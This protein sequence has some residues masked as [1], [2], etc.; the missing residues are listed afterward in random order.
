MFE[1]LALGTVQF[2]LD[3]GIANQTGRVDLPE[4]QAILAEARARG[5]DTLDTAIAYGQSEQTLGSVGVRGWRVISKLPA[6]PED[7]PDVGAWVREQVGASLERLKIPR[8]Y[9]VLLH[10]P[11]QLLGDRGGE[12]YQALHRLKADEQ[13]AKV[14]VSIY[15]PEEL[16]RLY[17]HMHFDLVQAPLNILDRRMVQSGWARRLKSADVELHVRSVFLQGLLLMEPGVRPKKFARW[18]ALWDQ[19]GQWLAENKLSPLE[20]CL[21]YVLSVREADRVVVGVDHVGQ[22]REILS[23]A[24]GRFPLPPQ[25]EQPIESDL[26]NPGRWSQL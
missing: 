18:G 20:A 9:A 2:G 17:A 24:E 19:W 16:E 23:A 10:R 21:R 26:I 15:G 14:G 4:V 13:A 12:L 8:L 11:D 1:R 5:L 25:W 3:Y 7:A 6:L 22:L